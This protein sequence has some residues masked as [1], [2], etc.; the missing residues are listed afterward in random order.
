MGWERGLTCC[1]FV[2]RCISSKNMTVRLYKDTKSAY[3]RTAA[4]EKG[5]YLPACETEFVLCL[6]EDR[7]DIVDAGDSSAEFLEDRV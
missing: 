4:G 7:T 2:K 6:V 1:D 5:G 3:F